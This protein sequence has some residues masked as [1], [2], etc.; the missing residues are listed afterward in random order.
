MKIGS[1]SSVKLTVLRLAILTISVALLWVVSSNYLFFSYK[2][3]RVSEILVDKVMPN[4]GNFEQTSLTQFS[5]IDEYFKDMVSGIANP[6]EF[7]TI[8]VQVKQKNILILNSDRLNGGKSFVPAKFS[9]NEAGQIKNL[10]GK[11]RTKGDRALHKESFNNMSLR[12]NLKGDDRLFGLEEFSV[13]DPILRNYS[14]EL[15]VADVLKSQGLLTLK[16]VVANFS[17]NGESRGLYVFEEVP[18]TI[19]LERNLKKAGPIFGLDEEYGAGLNS[20]LDV[21]DAK[22]WEDTKIYN[23]AREKLLMQFAAAREG[24]VFSKEIFDFDEWARYFALIDLFGTYH[25]SVPKSVRFYFNSVTGKFQP[26]LFDAHKGA[27][28]FSEFIIADFLLNPKSTECEWVCDYREFYMGF[29]NNKYFFDAYLGYLANYSS[30]EFVQNVEA[31]YMD[32]F[33]KLDQKFYASL[34]RSDGIMFRGFGLYMFKFSEIE[35]R[36]KL[37]T[38]KIVQLNEHKETFTFLSTANSNA[39]LL[40]HRNDVI[41][42]KGAIVLT[43]ENQV[44]K[45]TEWNFKK[46]TVLLL[47]GD[48]KLEGL[49]K[50]RP[51]KI[52]GPVMFVQKGGTITLNNV[53]F[54]KPINIDVSNRMWSGAINIINAKAK[55]ARVL[56][57]ESN[58]EDAINFISSSF[59]ISDLIVLGS[60][61]DAIDFD[62][63]NGY[64]DKI[65]CINIGND[66]VDASESVV[67][68]KFL[69]ADGTQDKGVSAGENSIVKINKFDAKNVAVGLVS[70]D[71]SQLE[72]DELIVSS[73]Q[74]AI[75]AFKK[76]PE[77]F[78]PSLILKKAVNLDTQSQMQALVS[79]DSKIEFPSEI[80]ILIEKSINIESRM[81]GVEFGKATEK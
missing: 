39:Q 31:I 23:S 65:S 21:Y 30:I 75:S 28:K 38:K 16:S 61:S 63:S 8:D 20:V 72:V 36:R 37:L 80:N 81:Y 51:L 17:F 66:C 35:R 68:I 59:E 32:K 42:P 52:T 27:G 58:A 11:I 12:V 62:F 76:K 54:I 29:L 43:L 79:I 74:L 10:K 46:P 71:G 53:S 22:D 69:V 19:T 24:G 67:N 13:Q 49:S 44:L 14:W 48:T 55:L 73:V 6:Q 3:N 40:S 18:S 15:L 60:K 56:I 77:Y 25:G 26:L 50:D 1:G 78:P 57:E 64:V 4:L 9:L 41:V 70:K 33:K 45:G 47:S 34:S 5:D 7:S 2:L